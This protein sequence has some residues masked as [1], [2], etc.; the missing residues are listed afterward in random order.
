MTALADAL[1]GAG[2]YVTEYGK[3]GRP[4]AWTPTGVLIHHTAG[5]P[6]GDAPSLNFLINGSSSLPGPVVQILIARSGQVHLISEG[7]ANHAGTGSGL[8]A[9]GIPTDAGNQYLWGI[10]VES[11]GQAADW[12]ASQWSAAHVTARVLL[13]RMGKDSSRL[14]RHKDYAGSRKIDTLYELAT[15]RAAV[16]GSAPPPQPPPPPPPGSFSP[17]YRQNKDV[18][19]SK[20]RYGQADSNSVWN[21]QSALL[22]FGYSIPDGP[23]MYYGTQTKNACAAFQRAQGWSGSGADGI[24]GPQTVAR[25]GLNW[26]EG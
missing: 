15:H 7:R 26:R 5:A 12:P 11:T 25:L 10:E 21:L 13:S 6:T 16:D 3:P 4:Y 24:A 1:S 17:V 19:S 23:T 2:L 8:V 22:A 20:M 14:W 18:W 9:A